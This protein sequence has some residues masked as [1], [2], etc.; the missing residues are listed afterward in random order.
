MYGISDP[1]QPCYEMNVYNSAK[2]N[3]AYPK[4]GFYPATSVSPLEARPRTPIATTGQ[5]HKPGP[6]ES[7]PVLFPFGVESPHWAAVHAG[8]PLDR[9]WP[10]GIIRSGVPTDVTSFLR[11]PG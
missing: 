3:Q 7:T 2:L 9:S 10:K 8:Q 11:H 5:I 4:A 1:Y 6:T